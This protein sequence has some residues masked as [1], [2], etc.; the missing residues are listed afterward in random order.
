MLVPV[1]VVLCMFVPKLIFKSDAISE[2]ISPSSSIPAQAVQPRSL[3]DVRIL[4]PT[5]NYCQ[6]TPG[7][8]GNPY[9][10]LTF[11]RATKVCVSATP[12]FHVSRRL[13]RT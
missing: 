1:A 4:G 3:M 6:Y 11:G 7:G 13:A 5:A 9:D 8:E 10:P 12:S 2:Y